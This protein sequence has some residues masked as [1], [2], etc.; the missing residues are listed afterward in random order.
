MAAI[1][2]EDVLI[3]FGMVFGIFAACLFV[4]MLIGA[5][6]HAGSGE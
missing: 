3:F 5:A 1:T 6:I 4:A 2:F